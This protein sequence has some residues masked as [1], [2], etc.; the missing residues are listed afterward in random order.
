MSNR[1]TVKSKIVTKN[2][3]T[4][5]NAI[6]TDML[7]AEM[8]DNLCFR[9]DVAVSQT[10]PPGLINLDFAPTPTGIR[11]RIDLI[12][13]GG[14]LIFSIAIGTVLD[15]EI[16][17]LLLTKTTGTT[18]TWS[19]VEDVTPVIENVTALST[20]LYAIYRKGANYFAKA[21]VKTPLSATETI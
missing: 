9:E 8:A 3:P 13:T 17:Y 19:G 10:S 7:N 2:I 18:V 20:V 11:D 21:V 6:L 1:T 14:N 12:A 16:K 15:G 5:T 4:V